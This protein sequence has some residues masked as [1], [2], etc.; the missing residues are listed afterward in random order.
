MYISTYLYHVF[1]L[2]LFLFIFLGLRRVK[3]LRLQGVLFLFVHDHSGL[4][5]NIVIAYMK[6]VTHNTF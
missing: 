6:K 4:N 2:D 5:Y 1:D 3:N